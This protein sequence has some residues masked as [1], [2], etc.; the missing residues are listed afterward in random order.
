MVQKGIR[1]RDKDLKFASCVAG[2]RVIRTIC[3]TRNLEPYQVRDCCNLTL[4]R[5]QLLCHQSKP[6][7]GKVVIERICKA[8]SRPL[9]NYE[10]G[11]IDSRQLMQIRAA[12]VFPGLFQITRFARQNL[13]CARLADGFLPCQRDIPVG[14]PIEKCERLNDNGNGTVKLRARPLQQVPLLSC[15][16]M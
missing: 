11:G 3:V 16:C 6:D 12:K 7:D 13:D 4:Q 5:S 14:V 2:H 8:D 10:A 1:L 9:H 15:L